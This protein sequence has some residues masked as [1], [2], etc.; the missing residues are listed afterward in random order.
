M[1]QKTPISEKQSNHSKQK[2]GKETPAEENK[3]GPS[4]DVSDAS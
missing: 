2:S 1:S 3:Q 4:G